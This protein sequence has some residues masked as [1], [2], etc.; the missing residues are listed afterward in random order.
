[1]QDERISEYEIRDNDCFGKHTYYIKENLKC[2]VNNPYD[3]RDVRD[4]FK[5]NKMIYG[6]TK[7]NS[8]K[9]IINDDK[10]QQPMKKR[11]TDQPREAFYQGGMAVTALSKD[12]KQYARFTAPN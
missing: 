12:W 5:S 8:I 1:M 3:K 10:Y 6:K 2:L 11:I 9:N 4:K 7:Y